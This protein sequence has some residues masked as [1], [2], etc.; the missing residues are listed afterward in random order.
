MFGAILL[1]SL[2]NAALVPFFFIVTYFL[3]ATCIRKPR[4]PTND[5]PLLQFCRNQNRRQRLNFS[6][7]NCFFTGVFCWF[8][9]IV[10]LFC[11]LFVWFWFCICLSFCAFAY[12]KFLN[13]VFTYFLVFF[14]FHNGKQWKKY[15][16]SLRV[17][18]VVEPYVGLATQVSQQVSKTL[19]WR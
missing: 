6:P 1:V 14:L 3:L 10:F 18:I 9:V 17:S 16:K 4:L 11:L 5:F 15:G 13:E 19:A 2:F 8:F 12:K 7:S